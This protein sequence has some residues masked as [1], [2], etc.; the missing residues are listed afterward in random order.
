[1]REG[2]VAVHVKVI[3]RFRDTFFKVAI[4]DDDTVMARLS[5]V[6]TLESGAKMDS[7]DSQSI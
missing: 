7:P 2:V 1:M 3:S 5:E 4:T 6:E